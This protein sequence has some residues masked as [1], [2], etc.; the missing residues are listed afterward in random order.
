M[1]KEINKITVSAMNKGKWRKKGKKRMG[2]KG[3]G[4]EE[5]EWGEKRVQK[6]K[7]RKE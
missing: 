4:T 3:E 5:K 1:P 6:N 7:G 2:R